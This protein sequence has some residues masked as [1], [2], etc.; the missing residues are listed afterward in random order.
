MLYRLH[1]VHP[2]WSRWCIEQTKWI[3]DVETWISQESQH[4]F[5]HKSLNA[6]NYKMTSWLDP[7]V[8]LRLSKKQWKS[9]RSMLQNTCKKSCNFPKSS[10]NLFK[11]GYCHE[12]DWSST[13]WC[14]LL[15]VHNRNMKWIIQ[16]RH[17]I[18]IPRYHCYHQSLWC[19][20]RGIWRQ[21]YA[22]WFTWSSGITPD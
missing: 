2:P 16:V 9:V 12:L 15:S 20:D 17:A 14:V 3:C 8:H 6:W 4:I 11:S 18:L 7:W 1:L 10:D 22:S 19:Q 5:E 21:H 13:R